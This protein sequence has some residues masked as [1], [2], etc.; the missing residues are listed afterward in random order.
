MLERFIEKA[1][2]WLWETNQKKK[3]RVGDV[4]EWLRFAFARWLPHA[5]PDNA[6]SVVVALRNRGGERERN[7][8]E[9][10]L[11][12][13]LPGESYEVIVVDYGSRPRLEA[14]VKGVDERLKYVYVADGVE[15]E[16]NAPHAKNV[17]AR[18]A[19]GA[20]LVFGNADIVFPRNAL[21]DLAVACWP[22]YP[23]LMEVARYDVPEELVGTGLQERFDEVLRDARVKKDAHGSDVQALRRRFFAEP[24]NGFD[25]RFAGWGAWD[26]DFRK[27]A[28]TAG[29][30]R[31]NAGPFVKVLHQNHESLPEKHGLRYRENR[32][33]LEATPRQAVAANEGKRFGETN[34]RLYIS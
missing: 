18:L 27:R 4:G 19:K 12:Q 24:L 1:D 5:F 16:F 29:F 32:A 21:R 10:L 20:V 11:R 17:G 22:R 2:A 28:V 31:L 26:T 30:K 33:L 34:Q 9:S 23:V 7:C 8:L 6:V 3:W 15:G 13:S 25:E 14:F